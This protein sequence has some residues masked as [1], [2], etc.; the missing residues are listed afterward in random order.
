VAEWP[1]TVMDASRF[2]KLHFIGP[3]RQPEHV[4]RTHRT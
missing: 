1:V 4:H 3:D 2:V